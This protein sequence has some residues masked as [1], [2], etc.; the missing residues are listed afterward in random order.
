MGWVSLCCSF[1]MSTY[2]I[3]QDLSD[4]EVAYVRDKLDDFNEPLAPPRNFREINFA[5]RDGSNE[6][7][8]GLIG[9]VQWNWLHVSIL[10]VGEELR[11]TGLGRE[12]MLKAEAAA[13]DCGCKYAKL[14]TFDFQA[15][16]FYES[17]GYKVIGET[18]DFPE[19]HCQYLMCKQL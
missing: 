13:R 8:G 18:P 7:V 1:G 11:G 14:H 17:L 16:G 19:G 15:R 3:S 9:S 10:W 2:R 12:L 4:D 6:I 5:L